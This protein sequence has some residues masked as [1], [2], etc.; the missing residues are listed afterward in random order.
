V[1]GGVQGMGQRK[2]GC[3]VVQYSLSKKPLLNPMGAAKWPHKAQ[4]GTK[5]RETEQS[6]ESSTLRGNRGSAYKSSTTSVLLTIAG[7]D[8]SGAESRKLGGQGPWVVGRGLGA[9]QRRFGGVYGT[10]GGAFNR[11][12]R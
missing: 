12:G 11:I 2:G 1:Y 6:A 10:G 3:R 4:R 5:P 9:E 8:T 7:Q